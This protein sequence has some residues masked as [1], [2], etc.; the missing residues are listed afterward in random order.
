MSMEERVTQWLLA[1]QRRLWLAVMWCFVICTSF[2]VHLT[3]IEGSD[4]LG[5]NVRSLESMMTGKAIKPHIFRQMVPIMAHGVVAVTPQGL[6]DSA[7]QAMA[8]WLNTP[9]SMF[10][11]MVS[12]RHSASKPPELRDEWLYPFTVVVILDYLFLMGYVFYVWKLAQLLFPTLFSV[13]VMAPVFALLAI[14][15]FCSKF[16]YIY[17][18]PVLFFSAWMTYILLRGRLWLYTLFVGVATLNKE[19][20]I[21]LLAVFVLYGWKMLPP[22]VWRYHAALQ[23]GLICVVKLAVSVYYADSPGEFLWTRGLYDHIMTNLDG[24][25]VYTWLGL[26]AATLLIGA[27]WHEKP[28]ILRCWAVLVPFA[29]MSW[30]IFGMRNEYRVM[31]EVFPPLVL[32]ACHTLARAARWHET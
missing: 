19:T 8:E 25:A 10:A 23:L 17:D 26:M 22:K 12:Y 27:R 13:Q 15:P 11:T 3:F 32:M 16:A 5:I 20:S 29:A 21:Y 18:F 1:H 9:K 7:T 2:Y 31:Y 4:F 28:Y 14:P 24:F 30:L 6:Q